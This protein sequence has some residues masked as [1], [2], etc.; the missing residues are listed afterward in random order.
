MDEKKE[1]IKNI[2]WF[3]HIN[4]IGGVE[5]Y[6]YELV[7]KYSETKDIQIYYGSG[8]LKQIQRLRKY[9]KITQWKGEELK[10]ENLFVNYG[11]KGFIE[12]CKANKYYQVIHADYK[13]QKIKPQLNDL[14]DKY[15]CVS[16]LVKKHFQE[17]TGLDDKKLIVS[18]NPITIE[19]EDRRPCLILG[20][21][22]R[23]T[24]EK[25]KERMRKLIE[26]LDNVKDFNYIWLIY[27]DDKDA[28]VSPNVCYM[29]PNIDGS[30]NIMSACDV[31]VQLSDCE[32]YSYTINEAKHLTR[33]LRTPLSSAD[34]MEGKED[35]ILNFDLSNIDEIIA[36]LKKIYANKAKKDT[37]Y[38]AK[39]D[40]YNEI[41][42]NGTNSYREELSKMVEVECKIPFYDVV[43]K[44]NRKE[45]ETFMVDKERANSLLKHP[46]GEL[47]K[48]IHNEEKS[49][50]EQKNKKEPKQEEPKKP[51]KP[52]KTTKK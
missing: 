24:P 49:K 42:L 20:S 44:V 48:V 13:T 47:V 17:I 52:K 18:Y 9:V 31:V 35:L 34:E 21:F 29:P 37:G 6:E 10:C 3:Q 1:I 46:A 14:F 39:E 2:I 25:G 19:E 43:E 33:V 4:S 12:H 41:L 50:E 7:K 8:D 40:S 11:Y 23:L 27:T 30:R 15:I 36:E 38:K 45:G 26:R 28:I 16:N 51:T 32:G 22:T 5:T